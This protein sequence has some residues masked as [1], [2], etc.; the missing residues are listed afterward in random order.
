MDINVTLTGVE[1]KPG[2]GW[3]LRK[4]KGIVDGQEKTF[5]TFDDELAN[6]ITAGFMLRP[7]RLTFETES[8]QGSDGR[9]GTKTYVNSMITDVGEPGTT[10][11]VATASS[12]GG[13]GG[14]RAQSGPTIGQRIGAYEAALQTA[15][16]GL[17]EVSSFTDV[18]TLADMILAYAEGKLAAAATAPEPDADPTPPAVSN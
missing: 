5:Q 16:S 4:F 6:K 12:G 15:Q 9:G 11:P 8:R 13:G 2:D 10:G 17:V 18:T 3:Q 14:S 1:V 7:I